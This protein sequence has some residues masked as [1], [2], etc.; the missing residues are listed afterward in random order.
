MATLLSSNAKC[1]LKDLS[2]AA[3]ILTEEFYSHKTNFI[4]FQLERLKTVLSLESTF[5]NKQNSMRI[6]YSGRSLQRMIVACN[7]K[8]GEVIGFAEID[9]RSL[10]NSN[11]AD[12]SSGDGASNDVLRSYMYNLAVDKKWKRKGIAS[13][14]VKACEKFVSDMHDSCIEK[15]LYLR[16]R[17]SNHAAVAL[18]EKLGYR[19]MNP[20][21]IS[22][23]KEDVNSGSLED[24]ELIL[25]AKD[26]PVGAECMLN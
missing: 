11:V 9:A 16:V 10:R 5:P 25:F 17:K 24:G 14:L 3:R 20:E 8:N 12:A 6:E 15:R 18:Y 22:L 4:T 19:E 7:A 26:L 21:I 1:K 23:N 13:A 2:P